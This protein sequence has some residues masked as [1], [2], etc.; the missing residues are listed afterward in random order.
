[1]ASGEGPW[2][3]GGFFVGV[4]SIPLSF[5]FRSVRISFFFR[6]YVNVVGIRASCLF[7]L[8][9]VFGFRKE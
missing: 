9:C 7:G 5:L 1:M 2:A 8:N 4:F 6:K 3:E